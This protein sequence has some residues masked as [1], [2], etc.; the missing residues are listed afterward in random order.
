MP[1]KPEVILGLGRRFWE[2]RIFLTAAELDVFTQLSKKPMSA[3]ELADTLNVTLRGITI[4]LD[5]LATM[6]L[7]EKKEEKYFCPDD[8]AGL[9]SK[10][11][12]TSVIPMLMLNIGGWKQWSDLTEIVRHGSKKDNL[13]ILG[14]SDSQNETFI[15]AMHVLAYR[16]AHGIIAV[17]NPGKARKLL[18]IGGSSGS[19]T[20]AF[21]ES[22]KDMRATIFELPP[23]I[24]IAQKRL[25]N[26]NIL[27]R[28]T[29]VAGDFHKDELPAGHDLVLLSAIIHL[30]SPEENIELYRKIYRALEPG[31]RLV[32]RDH[33]MSP[34]HTK[35]ASGALFAVNMLVVTPDGRTYSFEEIKSSLEAAGFIRVNLIQPDEHMNG[36]VEGFKP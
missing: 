20:M 26:N 12:P 32:I 19:Y 30:H 11:S 1:A 17:T 10:D 15:G 6:G 7:L 33:V 9:L 13:A 35:P 31:G 27:D 16:M 36:L 29:F 18:D 24:K 23:V 3:Q 4:L 8:L 28:I 34:D 25:A 2:S 5:A 22:F 21:L 14:S